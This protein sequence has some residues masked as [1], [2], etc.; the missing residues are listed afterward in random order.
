MGP[1][2]KQAATQVAQHALHPGDKIWGLFLAKE[3]EALLFF[4]GGREKLWPQSCLLD[5]E[6]CDQRYLVCL[7]HPLSSGAPALPGFQR[8]KWE[9]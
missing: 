7:D 8:E 4:L 5:R 1:S 3:K 2:K 9:G 6:H